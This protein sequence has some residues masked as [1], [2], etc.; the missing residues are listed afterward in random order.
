VTDATGR[1]PAAPVP[2]AR[3]DDPH[4]GRVRRL[5]AAVLDTPGQLATAV[6]RAVAA[7]AGGAAGAVAAPL[8]GYVDTVARHAYRVTD[9]QVAALRAAGLTEDAIFEATIAAALGAGLRRLECGL[10]ALEAGEP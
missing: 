3:P 9:E 6:R 2:A 8:A 4:A 10:A 1:A 7:R 5:A